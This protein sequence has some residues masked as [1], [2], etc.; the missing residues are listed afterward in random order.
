MKFELRVNLSDLAGKH[1]KHLVAIKP[2]NGTFIH[3]TCLK[4]FPTHQHIF[5]IPSHTE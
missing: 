4:L 1:S 2:A 3:K 5:S